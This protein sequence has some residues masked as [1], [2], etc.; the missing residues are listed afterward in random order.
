M[1]GSNEEIEI[2][3]GLRCKRRRGAKALK[4]REPYLHIPM[5][6]VAILARAELPSSA[7]PLALGVLRHHRMSKSPVAMTTA[8]AASVGVTGR[9]ARRHA[10][11]ALASSG[12]FRAERRG[13]QATYV[14]PEG[15]LI[16]LAADGRWATIAMV[17]GRP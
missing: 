11:A 8:F 2:V 14:S 9:S 3:D 13:R 12:L 15:S 4:S 17:V 7:W 6:C 10:I 5:R 16:G 1:I